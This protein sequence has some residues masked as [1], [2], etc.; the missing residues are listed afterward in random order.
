[1][2]MLR[3]RELENGELMKPLTL[4]YAENNLLIYEF[5]LALMN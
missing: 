2:G 5:D 3:I 1:M 4:E